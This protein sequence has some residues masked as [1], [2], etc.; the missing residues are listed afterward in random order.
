MLGIR[1]VRLGRG[2]SEEAGVETIRVCQEATKAQPR[3][4]ALVVT[5][6]EVVTAPPL[7]GNLVK[8]VCAC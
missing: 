8:Q 2:Y 6:E 3:A 1:R 4:E 7:R 5:G